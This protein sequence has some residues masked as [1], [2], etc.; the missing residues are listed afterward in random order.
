MTLKTFKGKPESCPIDRMMR[1]IKVRESGILTYSIT[2][3]YT[4]D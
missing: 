4:S 2:Y 1:N 3:E